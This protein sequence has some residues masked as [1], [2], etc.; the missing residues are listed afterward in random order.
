MLSNSRFAKFE[1]IF[2]DEY[3]AVNKE[4]IEIQK[5]YQLQDHEA[6]NISRFSWADRITD[7]PMYYAA[8][9]WEFPY[10]IIEADLQ[11]GMKVADVG[12]GNTPFTALLAERVGAKNVTGYDP[13]YIQDDSIE[14]HSHFGAR[15]S[16]IDALGINFFNDGMTKMTAADN[17]FDRVFCISVLE[18][19]EDIQVKQQGLKEMARILK[20]GGKLILTFDVA[21]KMPLNDILQNIQFTGLI[22][23][24]TIDFHWTEKRFVNYGNGNSV[25][26]FGLILEKPNYDIDYDYEGKTKIP[27]YKATELS[28]RHAEHYAV[29]YNQ[30]LAARDLKRPFG[31]LRVFVK[32]LLG[33]YN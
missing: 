26:V 9:M 6:I 4:L 30:A 2:S 22:P 17:T 16:Y 27:A 33:K 25:D 23:S 10:A 32:S 8:R 20:P 3:A 21:L 19:I 28:Q 15:K 18:H 24:G 29:S 31:A 12:C 5:K 11:Q 14:G 1:E 7:K 13:D